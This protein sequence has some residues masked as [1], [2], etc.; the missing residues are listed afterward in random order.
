V[1]LERASE[2]ASAEAALH[3]AWDGD[4]SLLLITGPTGCGKSALLQHVTAA[5]LAAG[6]RVLRADATQLEQDFAFGIVQQLCR[7]VL[8]AAT[9]V[10]RDRWFQGAA[11]PILRTLTEAR[12]VSD[13]LERSLPGEA[14][15]YGLHV[16][17][18][19]MSLDEPVVMIVDDLQ[20]ADL[21]S[22]RLLGYLAK[23]LGGSRILIA[24]AVSGGSADPEQALIHELLASAGRTLTPA[25]LS[26]DAVSAVI[27]TEFDEAGGR[28]FVEMCLQVSG[29]NPASLV[30]MVT[31]LAAKGF[32]PT[33]DQA[34]DAAGESQRLLSD[35]R[36]F[37]L[38]TQRPAVLALA[39]A[40][41][42]LGDLAE[43][44]LAADLAGL[45]E[46]DHKSALQTLDRLGLLADS[47]EI[48][49]VHSS[50]RYGVESAMRVELREVM[51]RKAAN[52]L[53]AGGYPA[54]QVADKLMIIAS[55][56]ESWEAGIL[57]SAAGT[58]LERGSGELAARYLRRALL[59]TPP[60]S[61][62][63]GRLMVE[64]AAAERGFDLIASARHISQA[65]SMLPAGRER[66]EA[67][68]W[69]PPALAASIPVFGAL[70][71]SAADEVEA[72]DTA[73]DK[74]GLALRT[75]ARTRYPGISE[76]GR[77]DS[78]L[79]RLRSFGSDAPLDSAAGRELVAVL[80]HSA[81][82]S[83]TA[84]ADEIGTVV[85]Q[86]VAHESLGPEHVYTTLPLLVPTLVAADQ[87][88][89][90]GSALTATLDQARDRGWHG[91]ARL[92]VA[93]T[94]EIHRAHGRLPKA[95]RLALTALD[96]AG[97]EAW[98]DALALSATTLA[99]I[100]LETQDLELAERLLAAPA[101]NADHRVAV[102]RRMARGMVDLVRGDPATALDRFLDCG[103][104][105]EREGWAN[106]PQ[107]PWRVWAALVL[108]RMGD[109][110]AA[111]TYA[112]EEH[113]YA[114]RWGAPLVIGRSLR[115][116]GML[117]G[118]AEGVA[119]LYEAV[120]VLRES[121]NLVERA[122]ASMI[123]GA[124]LLD[125]GAPD[126]I[127]FLSE[128]RQLAKD[129]GATWVKGTGETE[130][131]GPVLRLS[132][133]SLSGL[134]KAENSVAQLVVQG[135]TNQQIADSLGVTRR[136]VEKNLTGAYRKLS[137]NGRAELVER[138]GEIAELD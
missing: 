136:A 66:I 51:Y 87:V 90:I 104:R 113:R 102:A 107:Y 134:T 52:L 58:V 121:E 5:G 16:L 32:R 83:D 127:G 33:A 67:S 2:I 59:H 18:H 128:G 54:E 4:G 110:P 24:A 77:A 64:L 96:D 117:T 78:A 10:Q 60:D 9:E 68:L 34:A 93:E 101:E 38:S 112:A 80:A 75:E 133:Q 138:F 42:V 95:R 106:A 46:V 137:V 71:R 53:Y 19:A 61:E 35:R 36:M 31:G 26:A 114:Q 21:A 74:E 118:G 41:A 105:L 98:P 23:R 111:D 124:R 119:L 69:I 22:L 120:S 92:I 55:G 3:A 39:R 30:T 28:E 125:A 65:L 12:L 48:R 99:Q 62:E 1:L 129:C 37:C 116:R 40:L 86:L 11:E 109:L 103:R 131:N 130:L 79:L 82:M 7:P 122:R 15:L 56:Y 47:E 126:A 14:V 123:L 49:L 45:D 108:Q 29:G 13:G 63:R 135:W 73:D 25:P 132:L 81:A 97:D 84:S 50:V 27:E 91:A 85:R 20:W 70:V 89:A 76:P 115:L 88:T 8:V 43:P 57:R 6:A 72:L 44:Q 100:V 17:V 94:A